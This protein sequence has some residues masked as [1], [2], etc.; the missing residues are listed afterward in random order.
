MEPNWF[1]AL[2]AEPDGW[3]DEL[4]APHPPP[5]ARLFH[6]EDLHVT[7]AFLGR[8]GESGAQRAWGLRGLWRAGPAEATLG[9]AAGMGPPSRF[10]A[11][12]ALF[13]RGREAIEAGMAACRD[14]MLAAADAPPEARPIKAHL[15]FARPRRDAT[16]AQRSAA[17]AWAMHLPLRGVTLRFRELALYTWAEDRR[18]RQFRIVARAP[19]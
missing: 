14:P 6:R 19:L 2:P 13:D 3:F 18:E 1:V 12:S 4:V 16:M 9:E 17:L 10:S 11:L 8:A 5:H 7:V 15:T